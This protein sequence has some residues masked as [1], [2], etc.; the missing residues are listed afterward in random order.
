MQVHQSCEAGKSAWSKH[1]PFC[2]PREQWL[3]D[4]NYRLK[5]ARYSSLHSG[6]KSI[7]SYLV[8]HLWQ[9]G[10]CQS[11]PETHQSAQNQHMSTDRIT[12]HLSK[13]TSSVSFRLVCCQNTFSLLLSSWCT[14]MGELLWWTLVPCLSMFRTIKRAISWTNNKNKALPEPMM[15]TPVFHWIQFKKYK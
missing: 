4:A 10:Q 14:C 3:Q 13:A 2:N 8:T 11:P 9:T 15:L 5:L 6:S 1:Q 7:R 12:V